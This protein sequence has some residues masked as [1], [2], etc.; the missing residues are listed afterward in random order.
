MLLSGILSGGEIVIAE[1]GRSDYEIVVPE[2]GDELSPFY[3]EAGKMLSE[4]IFRAVSVRIPLLR[5]H[6]RTP[7][8]KAL[9]IGPAGAAGSETPAGRWEYRIEVQKNRNV[10]LYGEDNYWPGNAGRKY[11]AFT[12]G[13]CKAAA[14]FAERFI[15]TA[16]LLPGGGIS[17]EKKGKI[18]LPDDFKLSV[19]TEVEISN[20]FVYPVKGMNNRFYAI[21]TLAC[22]WTF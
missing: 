1:N 3:L 2:D 13:S 6:Q 11:D 21:P 5:E 17:V 14:V 20:N 16:V 12:L 10:R 7:G 9:F 19:G 15:G 22:K 4:S 8:K 18:A